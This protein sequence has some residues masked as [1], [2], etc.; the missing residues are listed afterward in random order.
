MNHLNYPLKLLKNTA[1]FTNKRI[2]LT[3]SRIGKLIARRLF[4]EA[5]F[6]RGGL[7]ERMLSFSSKCF[8]PGE[9]DIIRL[10]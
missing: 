2:M 9:L 5:N 1:K 7:T 6:K 3:E 4:S 10:F 8:E